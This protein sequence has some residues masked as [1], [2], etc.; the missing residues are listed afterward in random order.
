M[1]SILDLI[2]YR[3]GSYHATTGD[4]MQYRSVLRDAARR[5]DGITTISEDVAAMLALE[6]IPV[7]Q[8]RVFP[9]LYGTE[10]IGGHEDA[11]VPQELAANGRVAEQFV[12]CLG[13]DYTHK[14][15]DLAVAVHGTLAGTGAA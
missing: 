4:W 6:R 5:A 11:S 2:A 7:E 8:D 13:T 14:N 3:A 15:R 12:V 10:H 9:V 1:I